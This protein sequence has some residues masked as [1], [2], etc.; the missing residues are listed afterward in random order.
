MFLSLSLLRTDLY[1]LIHSDHFVF[2]MYCTLFIVAFG[3][4]VLVAL[5]LLILVL[6][7]SQS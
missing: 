2:A 7:R 5:I 1:M 3:L 4:D 6:E